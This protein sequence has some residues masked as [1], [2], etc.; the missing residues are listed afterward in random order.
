MAAATAPR[1]PIITRRRK[2][3]EILNKVLWI[4][5]IFSIVMAIKYDL[6]GKKNEVNYW[7][8]NAILCVVLAMA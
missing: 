5:A 4:S 2:T 1:R 7:R 8:I 3:V 6:K